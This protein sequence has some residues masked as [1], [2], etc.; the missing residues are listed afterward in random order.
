MT[1]TTS[2]AASTLDARLGEDVMSDEIEDMPKPT[3]SGFRATGSYWA[4]FVAHFTPRL[5]GKVRS[6]YG[7][8]IPASDIAAETIAQAFQMAA[9]GSVPTSHLPNFTLSEF[10]VQRAM[11]VAHRS[12]IRQRRRRLLEREYAT[13]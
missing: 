11:S 12:A 8:E 6:R 7:N 5:K 4:Q 13:R 10:A 3:L 2:V 1:Q 9:R